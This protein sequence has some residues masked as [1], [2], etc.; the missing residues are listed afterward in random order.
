MPIEAIFGA[1]GA[2]VFEAVQK[3]GGAIAGAKPVKDWAEGCKRRL[4]GGRSTPRNHDLVKGVRTAHL[5]ALDH[6]A[7][8]HEA[9][10][11]TLPEHEIGKDERPFANNLRAFLAKRLTVAS[12]SGID[13][14]ALTEADIG[15]VLDELVHAAAHEQYADTARAARED[16]E[17]RALDEIAKDAGRGAPPLFTRLFKGERAAETGAGWYDAF[18][19][20]VT[21]ELKTNERFR[22]IFIATELVDIRRALDGLEKLVA[23]KLGAF[24]DLGGFTSDVRDRLSRIEDKIDR[25]TELLERI[26]AQL[27][28]SDGGVRLDAEVTRL[29]TALHATR[30]E[31]IALLE[32][33]VGQGIEPEKIGDALK[34]AKENLD[35]SRAELEH[36]RSLT[37][38]APEIEPDLA[39]ARAALD[40]PERID[41]AEAQRAIGEA[42][43]RYR[44]AVLVRRRGE[45]VNMARLTAAEAA[46]ALARSDFLSAAKLYDDAARE[47][48]ESEK[49]LAAEYAFERGRALY[50]HGDRFPGLSSLRAAVESYRTAL[51]VAMEAGLLVEWAFAQK[52]LGGALSRLGE[53]EGGA[54]GLASLREAVEAFRAALLVRTHEALPAQ[55]AATQNDLSVTLR[56][57]GEREGGSRGL[58]LVGDA[59]DACHEALRVYTEVDAPKYWA[60][61]Q[62]NLGNALLTLGRRESNDSC[63]LSLR[64]AIEAYHAALR[65]YT[66]ADTPLFWATIQNNLGNALYW[67]GNRE[68]GEAGL[69]NLHEAVAAYHAALRVRTESSLPVQ[70][71]QTQS[72]LGAALSGLGERVGGAAGSTHLRA[73]IDAFKASLRVQVE[74]ETP[75]DWAGTQHNLGNALTRLGVLESHVGGLSRLKDAVEAHR[76][77]LRVFT[78]AEMP[79]DWARSQ[80]NLGNALQALGLRERSAAR[81]ARLFDA[82][83]AYRRALTVYTET[84]YPD[85]FADIAGALDATNTM[86]LGL[87]LRPYVLGFLGLA[88]AG[89]VYLLYRLFAG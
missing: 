42:R 4:L 59:V 39:A 2:A 12:D 45:A 6:V 72:N 36:L 70:W 33:I 8:R 43:T 84:A 13:H 47:L 89:I 17:A 56:V 19:L 29:E 58:A 49:L 83:E 16:A 80:S 57:L 15:H 22:S 76:A 48:P 44:D 73:A 66:E 1:T 5:C 30:A 82:E 18:S 9:L 62:S 74:E 71:A 78:E 51:R 77:A 50:G 67:L 20:F 61:V 38:E 27:G 68:C 60:I 81:R 63:P 88:A 65:V 69:M 46:I 37:N 75:T 85:R 7:R 14:G 54:G 87:T 35:K 40:D 26:A 86:R 34:T 10:L 32:A 3:I 31:L 52:E 53:L 24:P 64:N 28:M 23:E 11:L 55:W 21:E 41:L 79:I 25:N